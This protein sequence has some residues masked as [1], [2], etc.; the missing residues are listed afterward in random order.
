VV[1]DGEKLVAIYPYRDA[2]VAKITVE[3]EDVLMLVCGVPNV[4]SDILNQAERIS[5]EYVTRF[6]G[7]SMV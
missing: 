2:E 1:E 7:G 3:T 4:G 6:C 5:K